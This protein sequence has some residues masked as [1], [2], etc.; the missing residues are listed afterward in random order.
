MTGSLDAYQAKKL[1]DQLRSESKYIT[2]NHLREE[3]AKDNLT[4]LDCMNVLRCGRVE[5][6]E[7]ENGRWR[8][9]V[10]TPKMA[11][12]V[13]IDEDQ[14]EFTIITAWRYK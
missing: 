7:W 4:T 14:S 11:V 6:P 1:L 10:H 13:E 2:T 12:I 3:L 5:H 8:Y 9:L